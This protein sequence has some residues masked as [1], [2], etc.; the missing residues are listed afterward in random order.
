MSWNDRVQSALG[1]SGID[2]DVVESPSWFAGL[3]NDARY[4]ARLLRRQ[5]RFALLVIVMMALG[6]GATTTLFSVTYGVLV[7]PLPWPSGE[8]LVVLE[9]TR[10][11]HPPRFGAFTNTAYL[12]WREDAKTI[13]GIAAWSLRTMTLTGA[14]DPMRISVNQ[15][16]DNLLH[17]LGARPLLGAF[18][19]ERSTSQ[20]AAS[21][22]VLSERL[23]RQRFA[24]DAAILGHAVHLDGRPHTVVGV[25]ADHQAFPDRSTLAWVPYRVPLPAG[26]R[27]AMF[28][29]IGRLRPSITAAQASAEGTAR[30]RFAADTGLTTTA[31][32]GSRGPIEVSATPLRRSMTADVQRPLI[33]LLAAVVLLFVTATANVASLQLVRAT[34]RR[35]EMA[36]RAAIGAGAARVTRQLLVES[37]VVAL[38]GGAAGVALSSLLHTAAPSLLPADFPRLDD[39]NVG[40]PVLLFAV[41]ASIGSGLAFAVLPALRVRRLNLSESLADDGAASVG[42]GRR[43]RMAQARLLIMAG[44]VA[45]A[46]V[47]LVGAS[48]LGR[49]FLSLLRADRGFDP[50]GVMTA[51]VSMPPST[52]APARRHA[53]VSQML[54]RLSTTPAVV[55][56]GFTSEMPLAPGGSTAAFTMRSPRGEGVV[57]VQASPRL[58]SPGA[59][60]A[61]GM[62]IT[63]GRGF[64][65]AD[66]EA[67]TPVVVVNQSFARKYLG[68][69]PIGA[70]VPTA[71]YSAQAGDDVEW[72]VVGVVDDV[73]YVTGTDTRQ[74]EMYYSHRQ[75]RGQLPV[76]TIT[77]L[78]RT[79]GNPSALA[80]AIRSAVR[81]ADGDL[82]AEMVMPLED[83]LMRTLARPRLYAILLGGFAAL[84]LAVAAVGLLGV[85][86][87]SVAQRSRE[88]AVRAALGA[89]QA[90]LAG[91]VLRQGLGVAVVGIVA[92]LLASVTLTRWIATML[93]GVTTTDTVTFVVVPAVLLVVA[94]AACL[95]P[96]RR[97]AT[98]DPIQVLRGN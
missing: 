68:D 80:S 23:W 96:T 8:Q 25:L 90:Q 73:R 74:P 19:T 16:T 78:A 1:D 82:V 6:I 62:R 28:N 43:T 88:F 3:T 70:H 58:V 75:M 84:A 81:E 50:A 95:A 42:A 2:P 91:L 52:Y 22:V 97:A 56:A 65:E 51:L 15:A 53:L 45:I 39:V 11:G 87:Y 71:G 13:D 54:A 41:A 10:G 32:F 61:L 37:L 76:P 26:N 38:I 55:A 46:C 44:Q 49:S 83:R 93:Y 94:A 30:G 85:L 24:A 20:A 31:V 67:S 18:F 86:S 92:G 5:P 27:L 35:R 40:A 77:L 48:L 29:A 47:L 33:V 66:T 34:T 72:T 57:S 12:A 59:F 89:G 9:E 64:S 79:E 4:A 63:A 60:K 7:K 69:A 21:A 17:V 14:G 98:V 36:I